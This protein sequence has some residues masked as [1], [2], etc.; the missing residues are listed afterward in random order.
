MRLAVDNK[1]LRVRLL[2]LRKKIN[3]PIDDLLTVLDEEELREAK[4]KNGQPV[5]VE[6]IKKGEP[7]RE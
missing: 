1:T 2:E 4:E 3:D 6:S 5:I 7:D